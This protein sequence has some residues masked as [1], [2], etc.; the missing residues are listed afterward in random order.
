MFI[1]QTCSGSVDFALR[2]MKPSRLID[3]NLKAGVI[4]LNL[5][6]KYTS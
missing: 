3:S 6:K 4:F 2:L 5:K 1:S